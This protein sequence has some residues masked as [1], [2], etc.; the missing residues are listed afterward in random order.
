MGGVSSKSLGSDAST[1]RSITPLGNVRSLGNADLTS[2]I[3]NALDVFDK[4]S[5]TNMEH[6][7]STAV[8]AASTATTGRD[9]GSMVA[10]RGSDDAGDAAGHHAP[11]LTEGHHAAGHHATGHHAPHLAG[12]H[13]KHQVA[14]AG[15]HAQ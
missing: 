14:A 8:S 5:D 7:G 10:H 6:R 9:L 12:L 2:G 1:S 3:A 13:N 4:S 11:H 15:H